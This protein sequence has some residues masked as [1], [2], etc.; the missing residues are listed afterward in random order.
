MKIHKYSI[1][2][3]IE[4]VVKTLLEKVSIIAG[5]VIIENH[6]RDIVFAIRLLRQPE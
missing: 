4:I 1:S 3:A 5:L 2:E 6:F